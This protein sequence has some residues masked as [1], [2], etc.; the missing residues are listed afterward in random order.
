MYTMGCMWVHIGMKWLERALGVGKGNVTVMV[1]SWSYLFCIPC[2]DWCRVRWQSSV[3]GNVTIMVE[4]WSYVFCIPCGVWCRVTGDT[5]L[6]A[7]W[8]L[9]PTDD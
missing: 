4:S 2:G 9:C 5:E 1:E 3:K 7:A 6:A 8:C